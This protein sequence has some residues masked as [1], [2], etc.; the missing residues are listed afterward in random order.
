MDQNWDF[1]NPWRQ[2]RQFQ[3]WGGFWQGALYWVPYSV[4][5]A[6][7]WQQNEVAFIFHRISK[8]TLHQGHCGQLKWHILCPLVLFRVL[9]LKNVKGGPWQVPNEDRILALWDRD[10][11]RTYRIPFFQLLFSSFLL[12]SL[13]FRSTHHKQLPTPSCNSRILS[14][15]SL[16]SVLHS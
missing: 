12:S 4:D 15:R 2:E 1:R 14:S 3:V 5:G 8:V 7:S 13:F 11:R 16:H 10:G 6:G 9:G